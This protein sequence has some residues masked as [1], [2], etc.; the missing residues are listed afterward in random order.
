MDFLKI[1]FIG[2]KCMTFLSSLLKLKDIL[3]SFDG[4]LLSYAA[5]LPA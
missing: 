5:R 1:N 3:E 4:L 2:I